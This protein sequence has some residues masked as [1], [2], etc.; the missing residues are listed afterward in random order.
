MKTTTFLVA[1][2]GGTKTDMA[3]FNALDLRTPLQYQRFINARYSGLEEIL[4]QFMAI[5]GSLPAVACFAVAG[6]VG[7]NRARMT[8]LPWRLDCGHLK[9][10]FGFT[11]V[12]LINDLTAVAN[13]LTSL[14]RDNPSEVY[15]ILSGGTVGGA[16]TGIVAPGTGLGEGYVVQLSG[17]TFVTGSEG[18]HADFA[19]VDAEQM[20]LLSWMQKG[21]TPVSYESL[22]AGPGL[23]RLYDF[24]KDYHSMDE[25]AVVLGDMAGKV[26]R[27]PSIVRGAI[28]PQ[29]CP[30]CQRVIQLFLRILGSEAGNLAL[31]I[32]A[33]GGIYL[34][35]GLL[36]RLVNHVKFDGFRASFLNKGP[37]SA[38]MAEIPVKLLLNKDAALVGAAA[39]LA[40][41]LK[42]KGQGL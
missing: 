18:G 35:G 5:A 21:Q 14:D 41:F 16:V 25:S 2:V 24:C 30:L 7:E 31:K 15:T 42:E 28:A 8:N 6:I 3:I 12:V 26:D 10:R 11:S 4:G 33:K 39:Y 9:A 19:P 38:V 29:P 22:V 34:G 32:Y 1:D 13:C 20:A 40:E 36:P 23:V 37:M 27:T 17:K